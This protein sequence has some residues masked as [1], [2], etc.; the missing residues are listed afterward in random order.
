M[1]IKGT[2]NVELDGDQLSS[3]IIRALLEDYGHLA[4]DVDVLMKKNAAGT[5][6]LY[7]IQ[8]LDHNLMLMQAM[9]RVMSNYMLY[10]EHLN[11]RHTWRQF[12]DLYKDRNFNHE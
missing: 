3:V 11:F 2:V 4:K 1:I 6:E 7:E 5:I 9:D 10:H 8:D 12:V